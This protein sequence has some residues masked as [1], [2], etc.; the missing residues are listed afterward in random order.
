MIA[1]AGR[2]IKVGAVTDGA[3]CEQFFSDQNTTTGQSRTVGVHVRIVE[4]AVEGNFSTDQEEV[5]LGVHTSLGTNGPF[6]FAS[7]DVVL[8]AG[9]CT[10]IEAVPIE[11]ATGVVNRSGSRNGRGRDAD[12]VSSESTAESGRGQ[13]GSEGHFLERVHMYS[14]LYRLVCN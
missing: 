5:E 14:P 1:N 12:G 6:G 4:D 8:G 9:A 7:V 11:A 3:V 2:S 10:S 13:K